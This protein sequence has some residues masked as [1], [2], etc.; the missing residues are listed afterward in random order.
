MKQ[1]IP[2]VMKTY[3]PGVYFRSVMGVFDTLEA[4]VKSFTSP[5]LYQRSLALS[6]NDFEYIQPENQYSFNRRSVDKNLFYIVE[7]H[8]VNEVDDE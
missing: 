2:Y 3:S 1:Y 7:V 4:A 6:V 8:E 5:E